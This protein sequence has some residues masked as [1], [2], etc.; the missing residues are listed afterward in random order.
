MSDP[1]IRSVL[2]ETLGH[3]D[4]AMVAN[5]RG[6]LEL[7]EAYP[8]AKTAKGARDAAVGALKQIQSK[9]PGKIEQAIQAMDNGD[10]KAAAWIGSILQQNFDL[11]GLDDQHTQWA[12]QFG[13]NM[14]SYLE[15][16]T[17]QTQQKT[18][19]DPSS[20]DLPMQDIQQ[21]AQAKQQPQVDPKQIIT[22]LG[23]TSGLADQGVESAGEQ[24]PE[25]HHASKSTYMSMGGKQYASKNPSQAIGA[26]MLVG[27]RQPYAAVRGTVVG[28][29]GGRPYSSI[30]TLVFNPQ[31]QS[32]QLGTLVAQNK[33][34]IVQ[35]LNQ[36]LEAL[37]SRNPRGN[38]IQ[39][40]DSLVGVM[41]DIINNIIQQLGGQQESMIRVNRQIIDS[42]LA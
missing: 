15:L 18:Q 3:T 36:R 37:K 41:D 29:T 39:I 35:N 23:I 42:V 17:G 16:F 33:Q 2:H 13:Q 22:D 9:F 19:G 26:V 20:L 34:A 32:D 28:G 1:F 11:T 24:N 31:I 6:K 25:P 7:F 38:V 14:S 4:L 12:A 8:D 5:P 40:V 21:K 27:G 10:A 30:L